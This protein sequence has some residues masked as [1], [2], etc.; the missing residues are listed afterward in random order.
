MSLPA[1]LP[2]PAVAREAYALR[3]HTRVLRKESAGDREAA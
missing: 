1:S 3:V 2:F